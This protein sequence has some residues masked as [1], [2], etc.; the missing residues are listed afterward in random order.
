MWDEDLL[1]SLALVQARVRA[2]ERKKE[3]FY[4]LGD[5]QAFNG[6]KADLENRKIPFLRIGPQ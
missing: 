4:D 5:M 3:I 6:L 1:R 2:I